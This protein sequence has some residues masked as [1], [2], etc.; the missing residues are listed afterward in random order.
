MINPNK[1]HVS[2][3]SFFTTRKIH[4]AKHQHTGVSSVTSS[5]SLSIINLSPLFS[6]YR[7]CNTY[8]F[9]MVSMLETKDFGSWTQTSVT[10][11]KDRLVIRPKRQ[12]PYIGRQV[13]DWVV[14]TAMD[15]G[16]DKHTQD[17]TLLHNHVRWKIQLLH[18]KCTHCNKLT[19]HFNCL[20]HD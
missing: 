11:M 13:V 20:L 4:I 8:E 5:P 19:Y 17:Y 6:L 9:R 1:Q 12:W 2:F 18:Y 10:K 16:M 15:H 14:C 3:F 7:H